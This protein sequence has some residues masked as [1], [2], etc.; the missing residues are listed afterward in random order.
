MQKQ[1]IMPFIHFPKEQLHN[2]DFSLEREILLANNTG[3]YS[4]SSL[5]NCNT[6]KYHGLLVAPQSMVDENQYVLLSSLDETIL[7]G[8]KKIQMA[9]HRYPNIYYPQGY[10]YLEDFSCEHIPQWI[11]KDGDITIKKE[12]MLAPNEARVLIRYTVLESQDPFQLQFDPFLAFRN[13]HSLSHANNNVIRKS[14]EISNGVKLKMYPGFSHLFLQ[15]SKQ[16]QFIAAPDWHY[17][18]EYTQERDRGYEYNEDLYCP[19]YFKVAVKKGDQ[20]VF[21]AG[22]TEISP[23]R[24]K[25]MF[26]SQLK[27][28]VPLRNFKDCLENA[29]RQ[30]IVNAEKGTEITAGFHWFGRWGRDT[31]IA[32][33]G[34]TLALGE[35]KVCKAVIDT[36]LKDLKDGLFPNTGSGHKSAY[37]SADASLWFFWTLQLYV[38]HT[39]TISQL[40]KEYGV[41]MK[42]I[43]EHY[44]KGT[45]HNIYMVDNGLLFAGEQGV[46]VTWMDAVLDGK[47]VTPR[48]GTTVELN[49]LWYNAI[50]FALEAAAF[51]DDK[52]FIKE[53]ESVPHQIESSFK[54]VFWDSERG[55]LADY[56]DSSHTDWSLRPNQ[57]FA[58]SLPYSPIDE[59]IKKSVLEIVER[60]LLTP[61]GLRTLS[62][63]DE[64]YKGIC[65]GDQRTRDLAYHQGTVW[66]WLLGHFVEAYI[67]V[68]GNKAKPFLQSLYEKFASAM[69]EY[70]IGTIAEIYDGD[71]PHKARGAISQAWSVAE[72]LR[73]RTIISENMH[74]MKEAG[75]IETLQTPS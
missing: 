20:L 25:P 66:P 16:A 3:A 40:W 31:F 4:S 74:A 1:F 50:C 28:S 17:N 12:L 51:S 7:Q 36:M 10:Y 19:G 24:L 9:T 44:R 8:V 55:Y 15:F 72:L 6:R 38:K 64:H 58:V 29:A 5:I 2:L 11:I 45:R 26:D 65:Y 69:L 43:L 14:E 30:F 71:E 37:I 70:G 46:A 53:W 18:N 47:P 67:K 42:S 54:E 57:V 41:K 27:K 34:L 22:L 23:R 48:I 21:S 49:A 60:K 35:P 68:H 13:I 61:R 32:L 56:A 33:P 52:K 63:D 62:P 39:G 59:E 75:R 73:I